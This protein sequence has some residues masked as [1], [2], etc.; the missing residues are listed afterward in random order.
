FLRLDDRCEGPLVADD[1]HDCD[2]L[3]R[4]MHSGGETDRAGNAWK[5]VGELEGTGDV[6]LLG[7]V[8]ALDGARDQHHRIVGERCK[9]GLWRNAVLGFIVRDELLHNGRCLRRIEK[10]MGGEVS[11]MSGRTRS[12]EQQWRI[13]T[14]ASKDGL[15]EA[16]VAHLRDESADVVRTGGDVE[17]VGRRRQREDAS[18]LL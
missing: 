15:I 14:V 11:V 12:L 10:N 17:H 1:V 4:Y 6:L 16:G 7:R 18:D 3:V 13:V 8:P 2:F 9:G 5:M